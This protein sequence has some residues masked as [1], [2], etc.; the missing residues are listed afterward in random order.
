MAASILMYSRDRLL[1]SISYRKLI[2]LQ[3]ILTPSRNSLLPPSHWF[4]TEDIFFIPGHHDFIFLYLLVQNDSI[5][6]F[7]L[8]WSYP[9]LVQMCQAKC[10]KFKILAK[11]KCK[12]LKW[13]WLSFFLGVTQAVSNVP[14]TIY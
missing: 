14:G 4:T 11:K 10:N 9:R 6:L 8:V 3:E 1:G 12:N 13:A 7:D 5:C 2:V